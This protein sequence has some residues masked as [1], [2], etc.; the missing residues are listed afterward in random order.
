[1]QSNFVISRDRFSVGP[2]GP[3][4]L[5]AV[6]QTFGGTEGWDRWDHHHCIPCGQHRPAHAGP[7]GPTR[8]YHLFVSKSCVVPLVPRAPP[9]SRA[10]LS[11]GMKR[12]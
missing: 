5:Q 3:V 4:V 6:L 8:R 9:R 10:F 7:T 12:L 2:A 11:S 1:V